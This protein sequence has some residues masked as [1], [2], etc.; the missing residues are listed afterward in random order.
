VT[1]RPP[2]LAATAKKFGPAKIPPKKIW[3]AENQP[4]E[5]NSAATEFFYD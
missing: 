2:N 5:K 1:S 4:E 3:L